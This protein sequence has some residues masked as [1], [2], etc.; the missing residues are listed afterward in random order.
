VKL[1]EERQAAESYTDYI[2]DA[3]ARNSTDR[4]ELCHAY[5]YLA[6]YYYEHMKLAE[7]HENAQKCMDYP[8]TK[9]DAKTLLR[10]IATFRIY[11]EGEKKNQGQNRFPNAATPGGH[12]SPMNL[13]FTP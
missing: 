13:T 6:K 12:L 4:A 3:E 8:E 7:A 11:L 9:E 2:K 5:L 10:Q 1:N